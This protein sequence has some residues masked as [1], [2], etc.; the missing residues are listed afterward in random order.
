[1]AKSTTSEQQRAKARLSRP[2]REKPTDAEKRERRQAA[3]IGNALNLRVMKLVDRNVRVHERAVRKLDSK[4]Q[5]E[6]QE[7]SRIALSLMTNYDLLGLT[8]DLQ[9]RFGQ[10]KRSQVEID[11][12]AE[13]PMLVKIQGG[14][15]WPQQE[16]AGA[17][18]PRG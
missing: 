1:M 13:A 4:A 11:V 18:R 3:R 9:D 2:R 17:A 6:P 15:G 12:N 10:P 8:K 16:G 5:L 14:L 7:V